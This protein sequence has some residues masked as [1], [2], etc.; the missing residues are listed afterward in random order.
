MS[1]RIEAVRQA[2]RTAGADAVLLT[3]PAHLRWAVGFTGS[4]G[5]LVV[6]STG[7]HFVTDGRYDVQARAEVAGAEVHVP[8]YRL[9][10][11]IA[12]RGLLGAARLLAVASDHTSVA[13]YD[14]LRVLLPTMTIVPS[15]GLLDGERAVKSDE[16]IERLRA[17]Q[18]LTA[19]VFEAILPLI[20]P[21]VKESDVAAELV[22][23]HLLRGAERM[24]FEPIV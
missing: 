22:Y 17:A 24:A 16:E 9:L 1:V 20:A 5:A 18:A 11:Y 12:E 15:N 6:G 23:Q 10:E 4:N 13:T 21:G 7:A 14:R 8:G 3:H 19:E 2:A